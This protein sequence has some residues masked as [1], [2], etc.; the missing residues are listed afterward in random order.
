MNQPNNKVR[1]IEKIGYGV[2]D[3]ASSIF[4]KLFTTFLAFFYTDVFGI[5]AA[6]A[7]TMILV[8]RFFDSA[9]DPVMGIIADRTTTRWGKFR[10]YLLWGAVPF[11]IAGVLAF[12]TPDLSDGGKLVY[13]YITYTL[14][15]IVYTIVNVPYSSL[16][17]VMTSD[18]TERTSLASYRYFFAFAGG[19]LVQVSLLLLAKFFGKENE[20]LGWQLS[21]ASYAVLAILLFFLT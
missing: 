11:G 6:A 9:N 18:S 20:A 7:G 2:G 1:F 3:A 12:T 5:S 10:P 4:Y 16:L 8:I 13:A 17:G 21:V 15:M 14:L 19:F